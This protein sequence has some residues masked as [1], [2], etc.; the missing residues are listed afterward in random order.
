MIIFLAYP[1]Y[2]ILCIFGKDE[3]V[4]CLPEDPDLLAK[5]YLP[6]RL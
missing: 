2:P 3:E 5:L 4:F 1:L 6:G